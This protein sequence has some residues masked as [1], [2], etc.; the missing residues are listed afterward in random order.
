MC[1]AQDPGAPHS[2]TPHHQTHSLDVP[3]HASLIIE[4]ESGVLSYARTFPATCMRTTIWPTLNSTLVL[5]VDP[6]GGNGVWG[7][8]RMILPVQGPLT[9]VTGVGITT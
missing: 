9:T 5:Q 8:L 1:A 3:K 4:I 7:G 2:S 6:G